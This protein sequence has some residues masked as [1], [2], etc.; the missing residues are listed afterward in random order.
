MAHK[1]V[2][3]AG[4]YKKGSVGALQHHNLRENETYSNED[5]DRERIKDNL[6]LRHP[7]I[8]QYQDAKNIIEGRTVNQIRATSIWQ[9]EFIISS[10][11]EFFQVLPLEE[12]NRFFHEAYEYLCREFGAENVTC[13]VVHYDETTP[14]MHFDFVPMTKDNKL[15]R[16][17]VLTRERLRKIQDDMPRYMQEKGFMVERGQK[18]ADLEFKDRPRHIEPKKYK[19]ALQGEICALEKQKKTAEEQ[20]YMYQQKIVKDEKQLGE[21]E[22]RLKIR[23]Q[24]LDSA[25]KHLNEYSSKLRA[26]M[27]DYN[28]QVKSLGELP[29]GKRTMG[30]NIT[31]TEPEYK[32]LAAFAKNGIIIHGEQRKLKETVQRLNKENEK[33][34]GQVMP[35]EQQIKINKKVAETDRL[36]REN[37]NL[38]RRNS[39]LINLAKEVLLLIGTLQLPEKVLK[40]LRKMEVSVNQNLENMQER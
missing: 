26:R 33:L 27:E 25:E 7:C 29:K 23:Y 10:D 18:M 21:K 34:K 28:Y 38:K 30:G 16:K 40:L 19:K 37:E 36:K 39:E 6:V 15:S 20:L 24:E 22:K 8:S 31:L 3:H 17:E 4:N 11:K 9:S 5:I 35:M 13:A 2:I 12:Q 1:M 14:H 32:S